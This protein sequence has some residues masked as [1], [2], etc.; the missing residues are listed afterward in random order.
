MSAENV[1]RFSNAPLPVGP[2]GCSAAPEFGGYSTWPATPRRILSPSKPVLPLP[3][4]LGA[5]VSG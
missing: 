4:R 2:I 3:S 5:P 1:N